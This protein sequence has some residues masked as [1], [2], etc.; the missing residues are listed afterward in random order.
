MRDG[1]AQCSSCGT[2]LA[3]DQR[4]C[5]ECGERRA[6]VS[7]FLRSGPPRQASPPA[8]PPGFASPAGAEAPA[9][10][11][12]TVSLLAGIGV[13]LLAMGVGVLIG[14]SGSGSSPAST[15]Q[16][17][18]V[19]SGGSGGT[20]AAEET[21]KSDW[22][23]TK[24]GW[25]VELQTLPG[26]PAATAVQ[27]AKSAASGKGATAVGALVAEEFPSVGGEGIV[28]YSG[29]YAKRSE[30]VAALGGLKKSFPGAKVVEVSSSGT[31]SSSGGASGGAGLN[32]KPKTPS[33]LGKPAGAGSLG[34]HGKTSGKKY[35][36][37]SAKLPNVVSTG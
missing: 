2:P 30:A 3:A 31:S 18:S 8:V 21:F 37:E 10:R 9:P 14:R 5:L 7:E 25:T 16:V 20:T 15:P 24:K 4:Y 1:A 34:S 32:S 26:S 12:G 17:I 28:V 27:D 11:S 29:E 19:A 6:T 33:S 13:L 22:P 36:E 35:V 23:A